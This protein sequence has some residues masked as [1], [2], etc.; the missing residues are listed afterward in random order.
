MN[1]REPAEQ[2]TENNTPNQGETDQ[3]LNFH[4]ILPESRCHNRTLTCTERYHLDMDAREQ[5]SLIHFL[6]KEWKDCSRE[7]MAYQYLAHTL[8]QAGVV[9]VQGILNQARNSQEFFRVWISS[10]HR[11]TQCFRP[12]IQITPRG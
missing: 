3:E 6:A 11:L 5:S 1:S 8:E 4:G 12:P 9:G 2:R 7:L 10:S